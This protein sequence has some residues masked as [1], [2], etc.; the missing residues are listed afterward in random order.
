MMND[1]K[2]FLLGLILAHDAFWIMDKVGDCAADRLAALW[3]K[4]AREAGWVVV[5]PS[6]ADDWRLN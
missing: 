2:V 1:L 3:H 6:P 4:K 5:R